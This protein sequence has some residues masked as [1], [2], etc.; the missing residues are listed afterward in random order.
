MLIE[1]SMANFDI[2]KTF[3]TLIEKSQQTS[4]NVT[5]YLA[6]LNHCRKSEV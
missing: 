2:E 4:G 6:V 1:L 3:D 5:L